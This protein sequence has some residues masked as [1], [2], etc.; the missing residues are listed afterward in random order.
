MCRKERTNI[1]DDIALPPLST[2]KG[3]SGIPIPGLP[4]CFIHLLHQVVHNIVNGFLCLD[5]HLPALLHD[6]AAGTAVL[7]EIP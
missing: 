3:R 6:F 4:F 2:K 5:R 7:H 1:H